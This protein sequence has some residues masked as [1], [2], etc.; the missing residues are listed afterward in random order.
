MRQAIQ[1]TLAHPAEAA[2]RAERRHQVAAE[3]YPMDR[4]VAEIAG[5][6]RALA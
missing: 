4:Y 1:A 6:L 3:V 2:R 5:A